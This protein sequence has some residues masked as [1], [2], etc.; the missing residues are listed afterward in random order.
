VLT[1]VELPLVSHKERYYSYVNGLRT[2]SHYFVPS[3]SRV[4][5]KVEAEA[6]RRLAAALDGVTVVSV[7]SD[8]MIESGGAIHCVTLGLKQH[9]IPRLPERLASDAP[10]GSARVALSR[11]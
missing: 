7:D 8:Q 9:L 1:F 6:H 4:S 3:Y 11:R 10:L 5:R 2:P